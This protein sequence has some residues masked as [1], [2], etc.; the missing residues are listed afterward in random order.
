MHIL[1]TDQVDSVLI[2]LLKKNRINY[3]YNLEKNEDGILEKIHNFD[4]MIVRNRLNI[5]ATFL[6]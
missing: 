2:A 6:K 3:T 5:N 1:I 4:G